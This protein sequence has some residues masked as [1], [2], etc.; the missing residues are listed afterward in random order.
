MLQTLSPGL[1]QITLRMIVELSEYIICISLFN[2]YII[3][4][5]IKY[6]FSQEHNGWCRVKYNVILETYIKN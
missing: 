5:I 6:T 1:V 4:T 3:V 2:K